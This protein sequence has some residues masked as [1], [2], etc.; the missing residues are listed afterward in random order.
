MLAPPEREDFSRRGGVSL[1]FESAIFRVARTSAQRGLFLPRRARTRCRSGNPRTTATRGS[2]CG[3]GS[4]PADRVDRDDFFR[5]GKIGTNGPFQADE[6]LPVA[7]SERYEN[8]G[9]P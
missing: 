4:L 8:T 6:A 7:L 9:L 1:R 2:R 3:T 5:G